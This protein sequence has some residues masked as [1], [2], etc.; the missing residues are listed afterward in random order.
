MT[1]AKKLVIVGVGALGS[2]ATMLLRNAGAAIKIVDFDRV[3]QKN[4]AAQLHAKTS[5]GK[6]KVVALEQLMKGLFG[7]KLEAIPH[8]LAPANVD[9]LLGGVDLVLDCLDN[10]ASRRLVQSFV[11]A[12]GIACLHGALDGEGSFGRVTWDSRF[13]VDDEPA[14]GAPT[15]ENGAFLPF[16]ALT[17]SFLA[18]SAQ[19]YLKAGREIG[20][21]ITAG[22]AVRT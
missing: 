20:F 14:A 11:R 17:A 13:V 8:R 6:T 12:R 15:C 2:H 16:I 7:A 1:D 22:G 18:W 3:E 5:V 9:A 4:V 10:G 21:E 19:E